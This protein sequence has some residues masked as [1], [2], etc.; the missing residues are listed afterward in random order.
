MA[1][2]GVAAEASPPGPLRATLWRRSTETLVSSKEAQE[3][4]TSPCPRHRI[5]RVSSPLRWCRHVFAAVVSWFE[6]I[7]G[8]T[9]ASSCSVPDDPAHDAQK[10]RLTRPRRPMCDR[11]LFRCFQEKSEAEPM[12]HLGLAPSLLPI[13]CQSQAEGEI[14]PRWVFSSDL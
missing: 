12:A 6:I 2:V 11:G 5:S 1:G 8:P 13:L 14:G 9:R 7:P 3:M 4:M 10:W